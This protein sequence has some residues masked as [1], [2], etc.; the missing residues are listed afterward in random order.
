MRRDLE[1]A[2]LW[3]YYCMHPQHQAISVLGTIQKIF[4]RSGCPFPRGVEEKAHLL[5]EG[6]HE[7]PQLPLTT[8]LMR[9][10]HPEMVENDQES[11][12]TEPGGGCWNILNPLYQPKGE[13]PSLLTALCNALYVQQKTIRGSGRSTECRWHGETGLEAGEGG[14]MVVEINRTC[15]GQR[16][17]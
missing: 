7:K 2:A 17:L 14:R 12:R 9:G 4:E 3:A 16:I 5:C 11:A 10:F 1:E 15:Y 6:C 8:I 13:G